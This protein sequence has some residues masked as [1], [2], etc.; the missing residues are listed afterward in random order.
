MPC[1]ASPDVVAAFLSDANKHAKAVATI[2]RYAQTIAKV[3]RSHGHVSPTEAEAVKQVLEG[4]ARTRG[5]RQD[6]K[7]AMTASLLGKVLPTWSTTKPADI[8]DR[9]LL[10]F[11]IAT[12][13]RRSEICAM[14][15]EQLKPT[16]DGYVLLLAR[17][18]T[19]QQ[20]EGREVAYP[21]LAEPHC[22]VQ[23]LQA[24]IALLGGAKEG[25]L[26]RG[27]RRD[28]SPRPTALTPK[29]VGV[30][31]KRA[32]RALGLDADDFGGHSLRAGYVTTAKKRGFDWVSIMEQTGHKTLAT[33]KKYTRYT[34]EV[35][36]AT[37]VVDVL[38]GAFEED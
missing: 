8:R 25:P 10:M 28:G 38:S 14:R 15:I 21:R 29:Y 35:F 13:M 22:P 36:A 19:D 37:K 7:E 1:P 34:Q 4:I 12:A 3:H 23:A 16:K 32:A 30:A 31:V 24:W 2:R 17:S 9:A 20:G 33:A 27:L 5:V 18:K 11:G 26:F 6:A